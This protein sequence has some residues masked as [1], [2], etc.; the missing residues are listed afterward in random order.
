MLK[1]DRLQVEIRD[2]EGRLFQLQEHHPNSF[3]TLSGSFQLTTE[4]PLG[5]DQI[6][7]RI[8]RPMSDDELEWLDNDW[9]KYWSQTFEVAEYRKP[10]FEVTVMPQG[11]S[12]LLG[13]KMKA[14]VN[15]RYYFGGAVKDADVQWTVISSVAT[16]DADIHQYQP[17]EDPRAWFYECQPVSGSKWNGMSF[18][19]W[20]WWG[21][22]D[23]LV[24]SGEGRTDEQGNLQIEF[25]SASG[26]QSVKY[27]VSATVRDASH[28]T[29]QGSADIEAHP[30]PF[31][32]SIGT[33]R[34]FYEAGEEIDARVRIKTLDGQPMAN[35][36]LKLTAF[37]QV[38]DSTTSAQEFESFFSQQLQTDDQGL[39][40][41]KITAKESGRLRL[42][43]EVRTP[44]ED[45]VVARSEIWIAGD[46]AVEQDAY[47]G[48]GTSTQTGSGFGFGIPAGTPDDEDI[49][50]L[51]DT[52]LL[53]YRPGENIRLMVRTRN[54][55]VTGLL[56]I[57]GDG[58][59]STK[60]VRLSKRCEVIEIP[61]TRDMPPR[62]RISLLAWSGCAFD[63]ANTE[64]TVYPEDNLLNVAVEAGKPSY[65]PRE[66]ARVSL[67]ITDA[68]G[69]SVAAEVELGIVDESLFDL[70]EDQ[71]LEI[72]SFFFPAPA[73][74]GNSSY[75]S[76]TVA[77]DEFYAD[78]RFANLAFGVGRVG[79]GGG[80]I[81]VQRPFVTSVIPVI[82]GGGTL[83]GPGLDTPAPTEIRRKFADTFYWS[84]HFA[85]G[86]NGKAVLDVEVP[87]TL[88]QWRIVA[89]AISGS[90]NFGV[91]TSSVVTRK[92]VIVRLSTPRF[93]TQGDQATVSTVINNNSDKEAEFQVHLE[94]EEALAGGQ[95]TR[96]I[97]AGDQVRID[98]PIKID[99]V[100][101]VK[102][103]AKALSQIASD[104]MEVTLPIRPY[105]IE[106]RI[107]RNG[108]L[109]NSS[110]STNLT[111]PDDADLDS[112]KLQIVV[113]SAST[114]AVRDALPYLADYPYGCVEQTMSR[115]LPAVVA[116]GA[117]KQQGIENKALAEVLPVM[118]EQGLQRLYGFQHD[119]GGWGWWKHDKTDEFMTTYVLF[120]LLTAQQAGYEINSQ[121]LQNGIEA[122][123]DFGLTPFSV[124][125]L[126]L[127]KVDV[128]I[129]LD[130]IQQK[131]KPESNPFGDTDGQSRRGEIPVSLLSKRRFST[132]DLAYLVLAGNKELAGQLPFDPPDKSD[133]DL[134][135]TT[136]LLVRA[137]ASVDRDDKRIPPLVDW[138]MQ[139]RRGGAWYSTLDT[140]YAVFALSDL[141][142]PGENPPAEVVVNGV[143]NESNSGRISLSHKDLRRGENKIEVRQTGG[144]RAAYASVLFEF[145]STDLDKPVEEDSL[146]A[147]RRTFER[148]VIVDGEK[149][150]QPIES[151]GEVTIDDELRVTTIVKHKDEVE[152]VMIESPIPAGTEPRVEEID[153]VGYWDLWFGRR[154]LRDDRVSVAASHL[155][156]DAHQFEFRLRP[157][158]P[159]LYRILPAKAFPMYNPDQQ[160]H[161]PPFVI[162]VVDSK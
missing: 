25:D 28:M 58:I 125:V 34:L 50:L 70:A 23:E 150:W 96:I 98:W 139:Q 2:P 85:I 151:G 3:G 80:G 95:Q 59:H 116:A 22:T 111:I 160:A 55:P 10:E 42:R 6:V 161:S 56:L 143:R 43:A 69:K 9:E 79:G 136:A 26:D 32:V 130:G 35:Q 115:F 36:Q 159:G 12:S 138:L 78:E 16:V 73:L 119:D 149:Q 129:D 142:Q 54:E 27:T 84:A 83:G 65:A 155:D 20:N 5:E 31:K 72:R 127:A 51:L 89:R 117:M 112:A 106:K 133:P 135:R 148:A 39:A 110:W 38:G 8:P 74:Y 102:L 121:T 128:K 7:V 144:D 44:Q 91:A 137:L 19:H 71:S 48:L 118:V 126:R 140:A 154:E 152:R 81:G 60:V 156:G 68:S 105:G 94:C 66:K 122:I 57:E 131:E 107:A 153:D 87:D 108:R 76:V 82:A 113:S 49:H 41:T 104:A 92:D 100:G 97:P 103:R 162:E 14:I 134:V 52:D 15:T 4:P 67:N 101:E 17:F 77:N 46:A 18:D 88:G 40:T 141:A 47:F 123:Q 37:L 99:S 146:L 86:D 132:E 157:T 109:E 29:A 114:A 53:A 24:A 63:W 75:G 33:P 21:Q 90:D 62:A 147:V 124:Y 120:G 158:L 45:T 1:Q 61:V 30:S 93:F 11:N 145:F 13:D 64:I